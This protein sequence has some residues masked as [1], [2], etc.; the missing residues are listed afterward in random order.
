MRIF[1]YAS[2]VMQLIALLMSASVVLL[3]DQA[4]KLLFLQ[5][6]EGQCVLLPAISL[7]RRINYGGAIAR[8]ASAMAALWVAEFI[9][10]LV[11]SHTVSLGRVAPI[12]LGSALGGAASNLLD[13]KHLGG[14]V[15]FIDLGFLPV[16]NIADAAIVVGIVLGVASI[17]GVVFG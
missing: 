9:F 16:F 1:P 7:R 17:V 14:V 11:L 10:L 3:L 13:A 6:K 5:C 15:D 8:K 12:A 2:D 4:A